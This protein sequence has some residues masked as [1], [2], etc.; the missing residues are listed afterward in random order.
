MHPRFL[1]P[2]QRQI[3]LAEY[4]VHDGVPLLLDKNPRVARLELIDEAEGDP[5]ADP[6]AGAAL[7]PDPQAAPAPAGGDP[8]AELVGAAAAPEAPLPDAVPSPP[9]EAPAPAAAATDPSAP[10]PAGDKV[11]LLSQLAHAQDERMNAILGKMEELAQQLDTV[12]KDGEARVRALDDRLEAINGQVRKLTPPSPLEQLKSMAT[13]SGGVSMED[14]FNEWAQK[15]GDPTR[16]GPNGMYQTM[17][18]PDGKGETFYVDVNKVPDLSS[19]EA[20]R[21][22]GISDRRGW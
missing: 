20:K 18:N 9:A 7:A 1:S 19:D 10:S 15:H 3:F 21:S 8:A 12:G 13:I 5:V 6:Q 17:E 14:Y 2:A 11:D 16:V 22:L 4:R